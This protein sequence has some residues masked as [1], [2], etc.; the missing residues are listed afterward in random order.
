MFRY[1]T[2]HQ[3]PKAEEHA[4]L[5][6]AL[7]ATA[8]KQSNNAEIWAALAWIYTNEHSH[9]F[10]AQPDPRVRH[11]VGKRWFWTEELG[12]RFRQGLEKLLESHPEGA[13]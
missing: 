1:W 3:N 10:N 6:V 5:R 11:E 4:R 9:L 13:E 2:Y 7:E 12:R 8:A